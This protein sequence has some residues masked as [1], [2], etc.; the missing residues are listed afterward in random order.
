MSTIEDYYQLV[1]PGIVYGNLIHAVAG[2]LFAVS[3][4]WSWTTFIAMMA[5]VSLVIASACVAN[6]IIDRRYDS[7]MERT[8]QRAM[9]THRIGIKQA[10]LYSFGLAAIGFIFLISYTNTLTVLLGVLAYISYVG[11]YTLS[12]PRT[13]WS[14]F[15]GTIPGALPGVAGY[16]ALSNQLTFEA[17]MIGLIL[18]AWQLPH[19]FAIGLRRSKEYERAGFPLFVVGHQPKQGR[20]IIIASLAIYA[21]CVFIF[22]A[23]A[24]SP[25][26]GGLFCALTGWWLV[27]A[28]FDKRSSQLWAKSVFLKSLVLTLALPIIGLVE[29]VFVRWL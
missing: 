25:V 10:V 22:S 3:Y 1:K 18:I 13:R 29:V 14:T 12:K 27:S 28:V 24:L 5:G 26:A 9:A 16:T 20:L 6:N 8:K 17:W 7:K 11:F 15:I 23:F 19:F 21:L 2:A 4:S